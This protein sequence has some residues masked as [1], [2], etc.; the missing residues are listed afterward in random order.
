MSH[1]DLTRKDRTRDLDLTGHLS[2]DDPV[3]QTEESQVSIGNVNVD[4]KVVSSDPKP[5]PEK[6]KMVQAGQNID[7]ELIQVF[8]KLAKERQSTVIQ[9]GPVVDYDKKDTFIKIGICFFLLYLGDCLFMW[10]LIECMLSDIEASL[11]AY[12]IIFAVYVAG[13]A[14]WVVY[15]T[16]IKAPKDLQAELGE[17]GEAV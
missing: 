8:T 15:E 6:K 1:Q 14:I 10:L 9:E 2:E 13:L 17:K 16:I 11:I 4:T 3:L 5:A 7:L 12:I